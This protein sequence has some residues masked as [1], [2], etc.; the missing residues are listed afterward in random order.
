V[1]IVDLG[2]SSGEKGA[3]GK[4]LQLQQLFFSLAYQ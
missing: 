2:P 4:T 1:R 3:E